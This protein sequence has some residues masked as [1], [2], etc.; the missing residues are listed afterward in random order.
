M[1]YS[2]KLAF[3]TN[4]LNT[5]SYTALTDV[6]TTEVRKALRALKGAKG[7]SYTRKFL[8]KDGVLRKWLD[9]DD[10]VSLGHLVEG[11]RG[12]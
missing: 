9:S 10:F 6:T 12:L 7:A 4:I 5:S 2:E 3:W 8:Y 11:A 1:P